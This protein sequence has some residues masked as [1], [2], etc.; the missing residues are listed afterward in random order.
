[1]MNVGRSIAAGAAGTAVM[2]ML[3]LAAP[4]MGMPE[5]PIGQMLGSFLKIGTVLGW[6]MHGVIGLV[7]AATYAVV[8]A[9][10]LPGPP[11]GRGAAYGFLVFLMAQ[12]VVMP[13]MG[14]GV[15][16]GGNAAMIMGSLMGHLVYGAVVGAAYGV[17][18][19]ETAVA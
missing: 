11:A 16:S 4:M 12:V 13:M 9:S 18:G 17:R 3:M 7:L 6:V 10:R 15:F 14:A 19:L 2:T 5:M 1:M 8:F